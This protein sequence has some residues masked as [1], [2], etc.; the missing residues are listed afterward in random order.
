MGVAGASSQAA[1]E[2]A[3]VQEA[4]VIRPSS[5]RSLSEEPDQAADL[6]SMSA[7]YPPTA[8]AAFFGLRPGATL[9][10]LDRGKIRAVP[11]QG[12]PERKRGGAKP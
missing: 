11:E 3:E 10:R 9:H 1:A 4:D 7:L 6:R 5:P 8:S 12:K 2:A